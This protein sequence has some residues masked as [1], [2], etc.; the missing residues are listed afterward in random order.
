MVDN[1]VAVGRAKGDALALD[2]NPTRPVLCKLRQIP[3][4]ALSFSVAIFKLGINR[5]ASEGFCEK[6]M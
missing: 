1:G 4:V 6:E 2:S 5:S 3:K